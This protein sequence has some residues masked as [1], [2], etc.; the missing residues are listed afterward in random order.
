MLSDVRCVLLTLKD[1]DTSGRA[2]LGSQR[3]DMKQNR[4]ILLICALAVAA[5]VSTATWA[6]EDP[7]AGMRGVNA[8]AWM[9]QADEFAAV[10]REQRALKGDD[11]GPELLA[12]LADRDGIDIVT[13]TYRH[14]AANDFLTQPRYLAELPPDLELA[15]QVITDG[16]T[17]ADQ[18]Q[19]N[20]DV[21]I[22]TASLLED[23]VVVAKRLGHDEYAA[24]LKDRLQ[25]MVT[26]EPIL[27]AGRR[28]SAT[29]KAVFTS[30]SV[31]PA[32][33]ESATEDTVLASPWQADQ[34]PFGVAMG[35]TREQIE[36][37][38]QSRLTKGTESLFVAQATV[39]PDPTFS[40]YLYSFGS[41]GG[42]CAVGALSQPLRNSGALIKAFERQYEML[43]GLYGEASM[44]KIPEAPSLTDMMFTPELYKVNWIMDGDSAAAYAPLK[45]ITL[46]SQAGK[47][48]GA[49]NL[50]IIYRYA[51]AGAAFLAGGA[52]NCD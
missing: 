26:D 34:A 4:F 19:R 50:R 8:V 10:F 11:F 44:R 35:A 47:D 41:D 20:Q 52:T 5:M 21:R 16:L 17:F 6:A 1:G 40:L 13:A 43:V 23:G 30:V 32:A 36:S 33:V 48:T 14:V 49:V 12:L 42:V 37:Q 18:H 45:S 22:N 15:M 24:Q 25:R 31:K 3:C 46:W 28:L 2:G 9:R 29:D 39:K 27:N 38:L 51:N 7:L